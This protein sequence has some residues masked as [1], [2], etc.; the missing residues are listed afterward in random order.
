MSSLTVTRSNLQL[1]GAK[2][3]FLQ[4]VKKNEQYCPSCDGFGL[5]EFNFGDELISTTCTVCTEF[6]FSSLE[7]V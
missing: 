4:L 2:E 5:V 3:R 7:A 1:V 6:T